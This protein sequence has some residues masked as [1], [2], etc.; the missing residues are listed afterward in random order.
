MLPVQTEQPAS[1]PIPWPGRSGT[2]CLQV[3]DAQIQPVASHDRQI[4]RCASCPPL[5]GASAFAA[6]NA[7]GMKPAPIPIRNQAPKSPSRQDA[8]PDADDDRAD[9]SRPPYA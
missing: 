5:R 8:K 2:K 7:I 6:I 4:E 1:Q 9:E 3:G